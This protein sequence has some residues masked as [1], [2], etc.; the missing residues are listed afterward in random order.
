MTRRDLFTLVL[1]AVIGPR[2]A[3]GVRSSTVKRLSGGVSD[4]TVTI[5]RHFVYRR[6]WTWQ[7][8]GAIIVREGH[9]WT[10]RER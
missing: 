9:K 5:R 6:A 4:V 3:P 8:S 2:A 10:G 1:G 7:P